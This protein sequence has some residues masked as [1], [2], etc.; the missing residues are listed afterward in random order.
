MKKKR[1]SRRE[2][3]LDYLFS[4]ESTWKGHEAFALWL[5]QEISP[6]IVVDLGFDRGL[7]TLAFAF[8]NKGHV[9]GIDWFEEGNYAEKSFALE[10]AFQNISN[11]ISCNFVKNI[12]LI[13]GPFRE[14]TKSWEKRVDLLHIDWAHSY[15]AVKQC[16]ETWRQ[17]LEPNAVILIHD[18]VSCPEGPGKLFRELRIP[19]V[20]FTHGSGLGILSSNRELLESIQK[21]FQL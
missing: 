20:S 2:T 13:I 5:I 1:A 11:A 7:S 17:F 12:H 8:E 21:A 18:I 9:F 3:A 15:R 14:I 10:S 4:I 16:Y 19:K 6:K